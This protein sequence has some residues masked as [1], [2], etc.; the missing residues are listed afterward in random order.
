MTIKRPSGLRNEFFMIRR[1]S[2]LLL[3]LFPAVFAFSSPLYSPTWGFRLDLPEGYEYTGGD[4]KNR[5][6]FQNDGGAIFDAA[7]Y[8]GT[9][10]TMKALVDDVNKR[11]GNQG[12]VSFFEYRNK[13]AA[14]IE[15]RFTGPGNGTAE[16]GK[17]GGGSGSPYTG[18]GL[19]VELESPESGNTGAGS[20]A[21]KPGGSSPPLFLALAH[22]PAG[23]A[24]LAVLH[25]SALDSIA[26]SEAE[27][28]FPGPIME[29]GYPRGEPRNMPLAGF[30]MTAQ[31]RENDAEAAQALVDREFGILRR[32]LFSPQWQEAWIRFYRVI[33]RDSWERLAD[34]AFQLE[35]RWNVPPAEVKPAAEAGKTAPAAAGG[36]E[37][38]V[39]AGKAL[40]WVQSF[41]YERDLMGSDFVNL[42]SA[43]VEGRG[44]CDSRALLWALILAQ[45]DIPA[46]IMVS[47]NHNHAMGLADVNGAGARFEM[48]GKKWLVAET[49]APV[50]LGLIGKDVS[51]TESWLGINFE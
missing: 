42:V 32:Y 14:L 9:Y 4:G 12:D 16:G 3:L 33:Y 27:R 6:S 8:Q 41:A 2:L 49:T 11:L 13:L 39:F 28:R 29:F 51:D 25:L 46:A 22:G 37:N 43:A 26:P 30:N 31:I 38:R 40:A 50:A 36:E 35:R 21:G 34:A 7:V 47:R 20:A 48:E 23:K 18:W 15:L 17:S 1:L 24:D 19:C 44:D 5:F 45:A 10:A